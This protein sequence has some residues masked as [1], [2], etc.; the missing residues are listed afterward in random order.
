MALDEVMQ[1]M[2]VAG[3]LQ[4][5]QIFTSPSLTPVTML[6]PTEVLDDEIAAGRLW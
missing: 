1:Q 3:P 6:L 4:A 5:A 2:A